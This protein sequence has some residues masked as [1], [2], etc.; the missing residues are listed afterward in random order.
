MG[1]VGFYGIS[2]IVGYLL[3]KLDEIKGLIFSV[4]F[5]RLLNGHDLFWVNVRFIFGWGS[6]NVFGFR[7]IALVFFKNL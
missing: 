3:P 6:W 1:L 4:V 7:L 5:I 2:T